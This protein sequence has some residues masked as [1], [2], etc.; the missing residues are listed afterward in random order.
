MGPK[1][2]DLPVIFKAAPDS[3]G[4]IFHALSQFTM[5]LLRIA[6]SELRGIA[7]LECAD[8]GTKDLI[9]SSPM[10]LGSSSLVSAASSAAHHPSTEEAT[11]DERLLPRLA[12]SDPSFN[13]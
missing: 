1:A 12:S 2:E 3:R 10:Q 7:V 4:A 6:L 8:S 5:A 9:T 13:C 11:T